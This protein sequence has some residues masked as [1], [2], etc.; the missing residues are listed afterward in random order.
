MF[1]LTS[2]HISIGKES[3][4]ARTE[5]YARA[6]ATLIYVFGIIIVFYFT[7]KGL[8]QYSRASKYC[9]GIPPSEIRSELLWPH[10]FVALYYLVATLIMSAALNALISI[11][12]TQKANLSTSLTAPNHSTTDEHSASIFAKAIAIIGILL[13]FFCIVKGVKDY[14]NSEYDFAPS[15]LSHTS[16]LDYGIFWDILMPAMLKAVHFLSI[17]F[18]AAATLKLLINISIARKAQA[19]S[20]DSFK[21]AHPIVTTPHLKCSECGHLVSKDDE[22]CPN[23]GNAINN[24][25]QEEDPEMQKAQSQEDRFKTL[26]VTIG[27]AAFILLTIIAYNLG[28]SNYKDPSQHLQRTNQNYNH[29]YNHNY[30]P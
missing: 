3:L 15:L 8:F 17:A 16:A 20:C 27:I 1:K 28:E 6:I 23:C 24:D 10:L 21:A 7:A 9:E 29:N 26:V 11:S 25:E 19:L 14:S 2:P 30:N 5:K 12:L 4:S 13:A 18:F 22:T